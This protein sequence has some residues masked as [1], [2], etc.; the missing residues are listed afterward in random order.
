M[1]RMGVMGRM[2][3][4]E[5]RGLIY[6]KSMTQDTSSLSDLHAMLKVVDGCPL[7]NC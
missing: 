3:D 6:E 2:M 1:G 7:C 4:G 5:P